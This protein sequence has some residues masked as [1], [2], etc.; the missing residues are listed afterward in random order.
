MAPRN[1]FEPLTMEDNLLAR[2]RAL[3]D[4]AHDLIMEHRELRARSDLIRRQL[5]AATSQMS[6]LKQTAGLLQQLASVQHIVAAGARQIIELRRIVADLERLGEHQVAAAA[7]D[8]LTT[9]EETQ[10]A[11]VADRDRLQ[12]ELKELG[13][14]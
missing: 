3:A 6:P 9:F 7:R 11:H 2:S 10:A 4:A 13:R 14:R 12:A 5:G 8:L 1:R